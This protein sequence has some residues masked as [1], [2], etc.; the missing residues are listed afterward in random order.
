MTP[1]SLT[2]LAVSAL[3]A[4]GAAYVI[5]SAVAAIPSTARPT[6]G[7]DGVPANGHMGCAL[8]VEPAA[9]AHCPKI[10]MGVNASCVESKTVRARNRESAHTVRRVVGA[11]HLL[12]GVPGHGLT[13]RKGVCSQLR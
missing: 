3:M 6:R 11:V 5:I 1:R 12:F 13:W 4:L 8:G 7:D 9:A 2:M 10:C